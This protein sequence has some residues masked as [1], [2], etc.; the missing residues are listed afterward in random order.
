LRGG[1][2]C[3][4][5]R[6]WQTDHHWV[7]DKEERG[8]KKTLAG[9]TTLALVASIGL[10]GCEAK[11]PAGTMERIEAAASKAEAAANRAE[12]ASRK[13]EDAANRADASAAKAEAIFHKGIRK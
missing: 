2:F 13:A 1:T 6:R 11:L 4:I 10:V 9:I 3:G 12:M 8:M 7:E 5:K